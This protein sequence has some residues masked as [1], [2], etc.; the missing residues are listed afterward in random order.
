MARIT[1]SVREIDFELASN[2]DGLW[3][4]PYRPQRWRV[5]RRT[6]FFFALVA[7]DLAVLGGIVMGLVLLVQHQM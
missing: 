7:L 5:A 4:L 2:A 6:G 3:S 1:R